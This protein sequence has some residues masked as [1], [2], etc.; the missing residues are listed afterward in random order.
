MIGPFISLQ[1]EH[2]GHGGSAG[3]RKTRKWVHRNIR[4]SLIVE[5]EEFPRHLP[6][7][8]EVEVAEGR[9]RDDY[10]VPT[11]RLHT[12][13]GG[14][15]D[16]VAGKTYIW[17]GANKTDP[18][19]DITDDMLVAEIRSL[20]AGNKQKLKLTC[21]TEDEEPEPARKLTDRGT[22][23][24]GEQYEQLDL[25]KHPTSAKRF[26]ALR[27]SKSNSALVL[28]NEKFWCELPDEEAESEDS[29]ES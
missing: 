4:T 28:N 22:W 5:V 3:F 25:V 14:V 11:L 2:F 10:A 7:H 9:R 17:T 8:V 15:Y 20:E 26:L 12:T 21:C 6:D 1:A 13:A 24:S 23:T 16:I 18:K 27:A 29:E 19:Y